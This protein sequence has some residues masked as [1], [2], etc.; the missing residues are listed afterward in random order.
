MRL[1][2]AMLRPEARLVILDEPFRGLDRQRRR[3][4]LV[5]AREY[6]KSATLLCITHDIDETRG[7]DRVLVVEQ[8]KIVEAGNPDVLAASHNSRY[9]QLLD[10]E[11]D[12]RTEMWSGSKW[13]KV[14]IDGGKLSEEP[15]IAADRDRELMDLL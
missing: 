9:A 14:R 6:W 5:L 2:R 10:A 1:A 15:R 3:E 7:F 4:L 11:T 8:G 12:I 13:R